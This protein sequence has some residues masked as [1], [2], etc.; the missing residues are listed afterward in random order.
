VQLINTHILVRDDLKLLDDGGEISKSQ[1]REVGGSIPSC[2]I[3]SLLDM[4]ILV[5]WSTT[6]CALALA[7]RPS[8]SK[9]KERD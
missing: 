7:C 9:E 1:G 6:L 8:L 2:E 3:S 4:I 5:K